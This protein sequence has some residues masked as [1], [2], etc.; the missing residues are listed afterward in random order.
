MT[1]AVRSDDECALEET[2]KETA[3]TMLKVILMIS[4]YYPLSIGLTFYQKWFIKTYKLPLFVV[5]WHY[6]FKYFLSILVRWL[7]ECFSGKRVRVSF[8]EQ[9]HWLAPIGI[10][11]SFDIGLSNWAL[12]YVTV[13]LYTMA[14]SSSILFIVAFALFLRIERW[15]PSLG[16]AAGLIAFGL[17]LFT[18][19]S[20]QLDLRGLLLVELAAACTGVRWTVSQLV[21]QREDQSLRHPLDMVA[22][23]QP[24]MLIAILPLVFLF[25]GSELSFHSV[26]YYS[27]KFAPLLIFSLC[28]FGGFL[29]F[30]M[31]MSEYLLL[32]HTS[33][34]TLNIFGIIKEVVTLLLAHFLNG[35]RLTAVNIFGLFLC[36]SGM[37][38]HGASRRRK[39]NG[40]VHPSSAESSA[41]RRS[42]LNDIE[43]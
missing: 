6:V 3:V 19:R 39:Q 28:A 37:F 2:K 24:W 36:L 43:E 25:E 5:S 9:L 10:C 12:E 33:G 13:S 29:A 7:L 21:M 31:E 26:F 17:F 4:L 16:V 27:G 23:V 11:A 38:L 14:K 41:D 18:W 1:N 40:R 8:K 32:V 22:H 35:D 34:I 30:A 15:R 42:L 20:S